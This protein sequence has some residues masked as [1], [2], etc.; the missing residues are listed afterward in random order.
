METKKMPLRGFIKHTQ[1]QEGITLIA[2]IIMVILLIILAMVSIKA[3]T[4]K[5]GILASSSNIANE[6]VIQ[7]YGEQIEQLVHSIILKDSLIGKKTTVTSMAEE[8]EK[9]D[10]IKSAVPNE[11][12]KDIIVTTTDGYIY[13]VYYDEETGK[14]E[15]DYI[16]KEDGEGIP[17]IKA[18]YDKIKAMIT[19]EAECKGGIKEIQL[20]YKGEIVET[21]QGETANFNVQKTGWYK[22]KAVANN[23]KTR[24]TWIRV[25]STV[26]APLI[27]II[28]NGEQENDWYGK[29]DKLV[30]IKISTNNQTATGIYY[31][32]NK[33]E[34]FN[35]IE[36]REAT[37]TISDSGRTII[38]AYVIDKQGN[39]S[40]QANKEIKYDNIHPEVG[41]LEIEG[42]KGTI[43]GKETGW[44]KSEEVIIKLNNMTDEP[45]DSGVVG[46][47]YWE[48]P[49]GSTSNEVTEEQKTYVKGSTG[50][51]KITKEGK[52]TIG[53]QAKDK[54]GNITE[55]AKIKTITIYKD[56]VLPGEFLPS[57]V[58]GSE[59]T[60]GFTAT[61]GTTD[62]N[63]GI[64]HY[65]FYVREGNKTVKELKNDKTGSFAVTGLASQKTYSVIVEAV[66]NAGNIRT[67]TGITGTTTKAG[68][69]N[70]LIATHGEQENEWYGK[71]DQKVGITI[72]ATNANA[73]KI[74]Y[75]KSTEANYTEI[76][77]TI[78]ITEINTT[79]KY[80]IQA[81]TEDQY[82]NVSEVAVSEE[83]KYDN[84][85]PTV[86]N[87]DVIGTKG[88]I[89]SLNTEWYTSD[90]VNLRLNN[91]SDGTGGSGIAGYYYWEIP[92]GSVKDDVLE[93]QKIYV[94]GTTGNIEIAKTKEGIIQ[95]GLTAKDNA[96]NVS[97]TVKTLTVKKD[98]VAPSTFTPT[99]SNQT[100]TG[101]TVNASSTDSISGISHYNF[102]VKAGNTIVK[103][104]EASTAGTFNVTGLSEKTSYTIEVQAVDNAGNVRIGTVITG[105]TKGVVAT[106]TI[107]LSP[108]VANGSNGWY[109]TGN[110]IITINDGTTDSTKS[111]VTGIVYTLN[112]T[113]RTVT[114][115]TATV[116]INTDGT[117][118]IK[119]YSTDGSTNS[120]ETS[121]YTIKRDVTDPSTASLGT[122]TNVTTTGMTITASASDATSGVATYKFQAS[123]ASNFSSI[124]KESSAQTSNTYTFS[125][126][127]DGTTYYLRVVV[128]DKAGRTKT[129]STITQA[130]VKAN[131]APTKAEVSFNTKG[132]NY[133]KINAKSTD[134]DGDAL[135]YTLYYGTNSTSLTKST[136]LANQTQNV[137]VAIQTPTNLSEYTY[138]YWRVDVSDGKA[139][140]QGDVQTR[141][142]TYC[143]GTGRSC[144][145]VA[146][147]CY[148]CG[149]KS[150]KTCGGST[151]ISGHQFTAYYK[152]SICGWE[153]SAS[154]KECSLRFVRSL[155]TPRVQPHRGMLSTVI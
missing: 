80:T 56:S 114:G 49:E 96:G 91:L 94:S 105:T 27:E 2:L 36:G 123:T 57:I 38:Y 150:N 100:T 135:T 98:S 118:T 60:N 142:R 33:D 31:K 120:V 39:E 81:Y 104:S 45:A 152:C 68:K 119:A 52:I 48:I 70:I 8:M 41:E 47:Y 13:Q 77:G 124:A 122:P 23:G 72:T 129:S 5:E 64:S 93:S 103:K 15:I 46:Y 17:T 101:F 75:K 139:T 84:T 141:V 83:I 1:K 42:T 50:Q 138:Y 89:N 6:Y 53:I 117:H 12:A 55:L 71:D 95:L 86:G 37:L 130:T 102:Y 16:G 40:E 10:W 115:R 43:E 82:K 113:V 144:T 146:Y 143:P 59:T 14:K 88:T 147:G 78:A 35:F 85:H 30:E 24:S 25:S 125:G 127:N 140:T 132:T 62:T 51:I 145:G 28:S 58:V 149:S 32:T 136:P 63:S 20:I 106:P 133:I 26:T 116:T 151:H 92:A 90:T 67:G 87:I 21:Q 74:Y 111:G 107:T 7:Q 110:I 29:D 148:S 3:L 155:I 108:Q 18:S 73:T 66:D 112:G 9:E 109:K 65:N 19:A 134:V 69:P 97:T 131:T 121:T 128:T 4:G 11:E 34:D 154:T 76:T 137:Q 44:Y 153:R 54:A 61:A 79:G 22:I 99:I 126:L